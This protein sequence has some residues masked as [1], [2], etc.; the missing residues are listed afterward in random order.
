MEKTMDEADVARATLGL[1]FG[2]IGGA[3]TQSM[4]LETAR[5]LY[6]TT[7]SIHAFKVWRLL[8][9]G[10]WPSDQLMAAFDRDLDEYRRDTLGSCYVPRASQKKRG[11]LGRLC[12]RVVGL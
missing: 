2:I 4:T 1:I 11:G 8:K 3:L 10:G 5:D 6:K 9:H 12:D 7:G